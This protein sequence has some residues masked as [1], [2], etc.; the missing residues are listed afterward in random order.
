MV[1]RSRVRERLLRRSAS[2][3]AEVAS[4]KGQRTDRSRGEWNSYPREVLTESRRDPMNIEARL[5][6]KTCIVVPTRMPVIRP[7]YSARNPP[8]SEVAMFV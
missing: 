6:C 4:A 8:A 3:A 2:A 7:R 5:T 1:G